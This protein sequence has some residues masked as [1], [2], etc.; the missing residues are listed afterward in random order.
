MPIEI[1]N[2]IHRS[3]AIAYLPG[4]DKTL[5]PLYDDSPAAWLDALLQCIGDVPMPPAAG[6]GG[7]LTPITDEKGYVN[8]YTYDQSG[9]EANRVAADNYRAILQTWN[10]RAETIRQAF[11]ALRAAREVVEK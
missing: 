8:G 4:P 3:E 10:A 1:I 9:D 6:L 7:H 11:T 5:V 2:G